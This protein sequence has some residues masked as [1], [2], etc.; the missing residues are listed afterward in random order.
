[1][2]FA[3]AS[4]LFPR[5]ASGWHPSVFLSLPPWCGF[6]VQ[7]GADV[8]GKLI[9]AHFITPLKKK[10]HEHFV[11]Y[12]SMIKVKIDEMLS[13]IDVFQENMKCV[14][15]VITPPVSWGDVFAVLLFAGLMCFH[16]NRFSPPFEL[17]FFYVY[18]LCHLLICY[19]YRMWCCGGF[20]YTLFETVTLSKWNSTNSCVSAR[21]LWVY[22]LFY[23]LFFNLFCF[24]VTQWH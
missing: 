6:A 8:S 15:K 7:H 20:R 23:L 21:L 16:G 14:A 10:K 5:S 17:S 12:K 2:Y 1:M 13:S 9:L 3:W 19:A 11:E 18:L 4:R 22:L 24:S